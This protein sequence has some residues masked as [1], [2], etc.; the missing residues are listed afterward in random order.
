MTRERRRREV[1]SGDL[2]RLDA[3]R[4]CWSEGGSRDALR[5]AVREAVATALTDKQREV[6]EACF[7]EGLSQGEIARRLGITQQVVDKRLFG[8]TR[9]GKRVGGAMARLREVLAPRLPRVS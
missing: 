3:R 8:A 7:F 5:E 1:L 9:G 6:V 2:D 4:A